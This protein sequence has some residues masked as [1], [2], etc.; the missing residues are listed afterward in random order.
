[1]DPVNTEPHQSSECPSIS[2]IFLTVKFSKCLQQHRCDGLPHGTFRLPRSRKNTFAIID[3]EL[4]VI[5]GK[6]LLYISPLT[7]FQ[8]DCNCEEMG[9]NPWSIDHK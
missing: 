5:W 7:T 4:W 2:K 8:I 3:R 9:N 1:M 6:M